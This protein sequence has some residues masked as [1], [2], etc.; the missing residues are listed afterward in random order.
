MSSLG[1]SIT[2]SNGSEKY[3]PMVKDELGL[4]WANN[5]GSSGATLSGAHKSSSTNTLLNQW[6]RVDEESDIISIFAGVNDF[7][8]HHVPIGQK[9]DT[10][11]MTFYGGLEQIVNGLKER[12]PGAWIFFITPYKCQGYDKPNNAGHVLQDYV[13]AIIDICNKY[14]LDYLNFFDTG[15]FEYD[16]KA[17]TTDGLHPT[18]SFYEKYTTPQMVTFIKRNYAK[19]YRQQ[20]IDKQ[21]NA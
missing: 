3:T 15:A 19:F 9:G 2:N 12:C 10:D 1:D 5:Y 7:K 4:L 13:N 20:M 11:P 16:N 8:Y 17:H 18:L 21:E 6:P 14:N